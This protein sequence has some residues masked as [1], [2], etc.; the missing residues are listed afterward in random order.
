MRV[1]F[2]SLQLPKDHPS[3]SN[4][5]GLQRIRMWLDAIQSLGAELDILLFASCPGPGFRTE[6]AA[7]VEQ[8]LLQMW[9]IRARVI[10]CERE[11]EEPPNHRRWSHPFENPAGFVAQYFAAYVRPVLG[12]SRH[13]N[14]GAFLGRRQLEAFAQCL[15]RSP[16]VVFFNQVYSTAPAT[17]VPLGGARTLLDLGDVEHRWFAREIAQP[18]Q[19]LLK[20]LLYLQVPALWW[21]ERAAIVRSN[22]AFV[23][24]EIDRRYL[25][26]TMRVR[27]IDVI[28]NAVARVDNGV[29]AAEPNVLYLG[30]FTYG[31][32][33]VAAEYLLREVWP[34]LS[35]LYP[36]A[37]LL[38]A[39]PNSECL[40]GFKNPPRGV[41]FLGFVPDLAALYRRTRVVCCPI[42]SGGGTRIKILEAAS[43]GV[44]VVSTPLG[45]EGIAFV[46][47]TE[48]LL[49]SSPADLAQAC[50]A[51]LTDD[52]RA[53]HMGALARE[54]VRA[55]YSR[56]AVVTRMRDVLTG[57]TRLEQ[58]DWDGGQA[59]GAPS[60][61]QDGP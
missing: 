21:G 51:L 47:E 23:C 48:I 38:I 43:Y 32:N 55:Q 9:G 54:R 27:N 33:I 41:E 24:S 52:V 20:P 50:V 5:G 31:P 19:W 10:V 39:G 29:L 58:A 3:G 7:S 42:Q 46:P 49:R 36:E 61:M 45:A 12:P 60:E 2:V 25:S 4:N 56:D 18:P 44:P 14:F 59:S 15:A 11:P 13:P 17:L 22:R 16:T 35:R 26:R 6:P 37:R 8:R 57:D 30:T 28:P 40:T 53:R 34:H 1:L